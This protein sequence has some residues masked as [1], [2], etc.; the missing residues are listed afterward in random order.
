M[1]ELTNDPVGRL[2]DESVLN[3]DEKFWQKK[4][5]ILK[6]LLSDEVKRKEFLNNEDS[7]FLLY[8]LYSTKIHCCETLLRILIITRKKHFHPLIPLIRLSFS[9]FR[10]ELDKMNNNLDEYLEN[11]DKFFKEVFYP[12]PN[13]EQTKVDQSTKQLKT[14]VNLIISEYLDHGAYNVFKH[15]F[16]GSISN[17]NWLSMDKTPIGTAEHMI[18]WCELEKYQDHYKLHHKSK[19]ISPDRELNIVK[20]CTLILSQL[21]AIKRAR[22]NKTPVQVGFFNDTNLHKVFSIYSYDATLGNMN[23]QYEIDLPKDF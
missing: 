10:K 8:E 13:L 5:V 17:K 20:I 3:F 9:T 11:S 22:L 7:N 21:F 6:T 16:Y 4:A 15:G 19:A 1:V 18:S 12:F 2:E 23:F 14:A